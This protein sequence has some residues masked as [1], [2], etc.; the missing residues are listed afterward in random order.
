MRQFI[1]SSDFDHSQPLNITDDGGVDDAPLQIDMRKAMP[2]PKE[3]FARWRQRLSE[4]KMAEDF[5]M[6]STIQEKDWDDFREKYG[7]VAYISTRY[8]TDLYPVLFPGD[9]E[10]KLLKDEL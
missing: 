7:F 8:L 2:G 10:G 4:K 6:A 1:V 5:F 9:E 3:T